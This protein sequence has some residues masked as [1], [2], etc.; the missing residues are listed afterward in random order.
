VVAVVLE[1]VPPPETD[2]VTPPGATS[3]MTVAVRGRVWDSTRPPRFGEM[4][5]LGVILIVT[6]VEEPHPAAL[7]SMNVTIRLKVRARCTF[8]GRCIDEKASLR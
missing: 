5:T 7:N 4:A 8:T 1:K 2:H 6:R 3:F